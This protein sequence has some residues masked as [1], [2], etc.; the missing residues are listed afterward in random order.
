MNEIAR[1]IAAEIGGVL[2][3]QVAAAIALLVEQEGSVPFVARYRYIISFIEFD[4]LVLQ[5]PL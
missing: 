2:A 4:I 5:G 3:N 1:S